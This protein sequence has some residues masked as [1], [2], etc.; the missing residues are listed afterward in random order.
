MASV[1]I[2]YTTTRALPST[3]RRS[4]RSSNTSEVKTK[5]ST[6]TSTAPPSTAFDLTPWVCWRLLSKNNNTTPPASVLKN[7]P[8]EW[9]RIKAVVINKIAVKGFHTCKINRS[10]ACSLPIGKAKPRR[11]DRR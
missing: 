6:A 9:V 3:V 7:P 10:I 8:L 11:R 5:A 4:I 2:P 1:V